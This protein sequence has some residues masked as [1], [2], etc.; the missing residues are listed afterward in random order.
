MGVGVGWYFPNKNFKPKRFSKLHYISRFSG[1]HVT[2][3]RVL[4]DIDLDFQS[5]SCY[6]TIMILFKGNWAISYM[7]ALSFFT[8]LSPMPSGKMKTF[9][10]SHSKRLI[11]ERKCPKLIFCEIAFMKTAPS[12]VK[13]FFWQHSLTS[14]VIVVV[15]IHVKYTFHKIF[16]FANTILAGSVFSALPVSIRITAIL[17]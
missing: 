16:I 3:K 12:T 6:T 8:K 7:L 4:A 1:S 15:G 9:L 2:S 17:S 10:K 13:L 11:I 5:Y 14:Q